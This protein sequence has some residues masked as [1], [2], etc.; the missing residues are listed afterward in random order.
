MWKITLNESRGDGITEKG[1]QVDDEIDSEAHSQGIRKTQQAQGNCG[2]AG[3][4]RDTEKLCKAPY[5]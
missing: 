5:A 2:D 4:G 1:S 3:R